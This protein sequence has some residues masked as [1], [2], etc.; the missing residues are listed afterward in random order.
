MLNLFNFL[1]ILREILPVKDLKPSKSPGGPLCLTGQPPGCKDEP[2]GCSAQH[3]CAAKAPDLMCTHT[4]FFSISLTLS[5]PPQ[6]TCSLMNFHIAAR[7]AGPT[8]YGCFVPLYSE[9]VGYK[10]LKLCWTHSSQIS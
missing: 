3:I 2:L 7:I 6:F 1:N 5:Y 4:S 8:N 9:E 10:L